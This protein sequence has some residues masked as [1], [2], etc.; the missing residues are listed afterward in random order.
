MIDCLF[1]LI[2]GGWVQTSN[3]RAP[4]AFC[5][6]PG[7][8]ETLFGPQL[9]HIK[10]FILRQ[11]VLQAGRPPIAQAGLLV[12]LFILGRFIGKKGRLAFAMATKVTTS[13]RINGRMSIGDQSQP[14][15]RLHNSPPPN[16]PPNVESSMMS[17]LITGEQCEAKRP[18]SPPS[19]PLPSP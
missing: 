5:C 2:W 6:L 18:Q 8:K 12:S 15:P 1:I 10:L 13:F 19:R 9:R 17:S 3:P 4:G 11:Y 16:R 7:L 14:P